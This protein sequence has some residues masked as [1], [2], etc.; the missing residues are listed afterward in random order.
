LY[1]DLLR[2]RRLSQ[3]VVVVIRRVASVWT[4]VGLVVAGLLL[5]AQPAFADSVG[6]TLA[7]I[8]SWVQGIL[9]A[10]GV[11]GFV[12]GGAFF[13]FDHTIGG[14]ERGKQFM[15]GSVGGV[16][17]GLLAGPIVRL[18]AGFVAR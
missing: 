1:D 5:T 6:D 3:E 8:T 16:M 17:L 4:A 14:Q 2:P 10:L 9:I 13:I 18:F 11:L 12:L 15:V 7:N